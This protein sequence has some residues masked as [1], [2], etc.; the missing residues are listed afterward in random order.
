MNG[1]GDRIRKVVFDYGALVLGI[2]GTAWAIY[3]IFGGV[4]VRLGIVEAKLEAVPVLSSDIKKMN[5][6][7]NA[8]GQNVA[9]MCV[10]VGKDLCKPYRGQ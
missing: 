10:T 2:F 6:N 9:I 8:I 7:I 5:E 4:D 3:S 1:N